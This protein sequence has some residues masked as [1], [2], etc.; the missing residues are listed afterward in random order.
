MCFKININTK[1][2]L[3]S[4]ANACWYQWPQ[5]QCFLLKHVYMWR[6]SNKIEPSHSY[7]QN[8]FRL[9]TIGNY[10]RLFVPQVLSTLSAILS[11][12]FLLNLGR[13]I[14]VY[15]LQFG[16]AIN[17]T[18]SRSRYQFSHTKKLFDWKNVFVSKK[19]K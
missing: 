13:Q 18:M 14:L 1:Y 19:D 7:K 5:C 16:Y 11:L 6:L 3:I 8:H 9:W 15:L 4:N 10:S 12:E 2:F 17:R